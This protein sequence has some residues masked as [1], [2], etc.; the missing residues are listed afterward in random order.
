MLNIH[1]YPSVFVHESRI[2]REAAAVARMGAFDLVQLVGTRAD[3]LPERQEL[4][5]GVEAVRLPPRK[6]RSRGLGKLASHL[7]WSFNALR[8]CLGRRPACINCHS[9]TVLP[10]GVIVKALTGAKLIYDAHEL[11]TET[12]NLGGVRKALSK[13]L[14]RALIGACD[15]AIFVSASIESW[16]RQRYRL[17]R[18]SVVYNAPAAPVP[19]QTAYFREKFEIPADKAIFLYLG[20]LGPGRG[21][22]PLLAAVERVPEAVLVVMG[23]GPLKSV[24]AQ[25]AK[26]SDRIHLH[27]A[28]APEAV[29]GLAASADFGVS[30]MEPDSLNHDYAMPNKL[31]E[32]A[33]AGLPVL[34][35]NTRE[36]AALVSTHRIGA[37][38]AAATPDGIAAAMR[39]L[40]EADAGAFG[41]GLAQVQRQYSWQAQ[42]AK[43][44]EVYRR[45]GFHGPEPAPVSTPA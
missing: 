34:V 6:A 18:T 26:R 1:L 40:I 42:E 39:E 5:P 36:Q 3:G 32:Y 38:A 19:A 11:E 16:Y 4:S 24:V 30:V 37:V 33:M 21:L 12:A 22:E 45:L 20:K 43:L 28:V 17:A 29:M 27:A 10:I 14:E 8:Y 31:F 35:T 44:A 23:Y 7:G 13:M 15:E 9:L 25:T 41:P 2:L